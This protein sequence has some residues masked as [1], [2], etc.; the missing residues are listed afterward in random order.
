MR[1]GGE[2]G[3][4][5]AWVVEYEDGSFGMLTTLEAYRR[6]GLARVVLGD[7]IQ[8]LVMEGGG[9][10]LAQRPLFCYVVETNMPSLSL[11]RSMGFEATG[12]FSWQS[13]TL[14]GQ[15]AA[16]AASRL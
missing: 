12:V 2:H 10:D 7:L 9:R 14:E 1:E 4:A 3:Q 11:L 6:R 8:Q 13:W 5:V 16:D 15:G